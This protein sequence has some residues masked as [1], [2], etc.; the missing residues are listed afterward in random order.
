MLAIMKLSYSVVGL[1][2]HVAKLKVELCLGK[3]IRAVFQ[4]KSKITHPVGGGEEQI[5]LHQRPRRFQNK[6]TFFSAMDISFFKYV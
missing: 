2:K 4:S 1:L 6:V 5:I 3:A